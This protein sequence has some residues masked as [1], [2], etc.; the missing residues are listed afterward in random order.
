[1]DSLGNP[2]KGYRLPT[3]RGVR[4][5]LEANCESPDQDDAKSIRRWLDGLPKTLGY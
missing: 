1:M 2:E 3:R 4:V 5:I